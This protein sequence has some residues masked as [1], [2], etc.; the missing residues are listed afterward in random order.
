RAGSA[1]GRQGRS[2]SAAVA[3]GWRWTSGGAA[4]A[5]VRYHAIIRGQEHLVEVSVHGSLRRVA[6]HPGAEAVQGVAPRVLE[7]DAVHVGA[8]GLSI[9]EGGRSFSCSL[10]PGKE[11]RITV[12]VGDE[13]HPLEL[14]DER[15]LRLRRATGTFS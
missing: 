9:L 11:G 1:L 4:E 2:G 14:L 8:L 3:V 5:P 6:I 7:V 12:Q 10:E 15:R 13:L